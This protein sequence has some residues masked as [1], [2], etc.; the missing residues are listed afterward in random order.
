MIILQVSPMSQNFWIAGIE[1]LLLLALAAYIGWW[2]AR[3]TFAGQLAG[4][5]AD[6]H[7]R[8]KELNDCHKSQLIISTPPPA[9]IEPV[10][11]ES[12]APIAVIDEA[13]NG[14]DDLEIIEGI[15]PK[16]EELLN[17]EGISTFAQLAATSA[18]AIKAILHA[19][20]PRFQVHDPGT[21]PQQAALARDGKWDELKQ[22]QDEL[23]KGKLD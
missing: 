10:R 22:W 15:G 8:H 7:A 17:K 6:V 1:A 21:W 16:I 18:E 23:N 19:A 12:F 4:L 20:G 5:E 13:L 2:I 14:P 11:V 3:R 9:R